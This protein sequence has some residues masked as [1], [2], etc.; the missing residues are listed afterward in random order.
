MFLKDAT[1]IKFYLMHSKY[2]T[3]SSQNHCTTSSKSTSPF[4]F[5]SNKKAITNNN[6]SLEPRIR[7]TSAYQPYHKKQ[8]KTRSAEATKR[9]RTSMRAPN[10]HS[11]SSS[12]R[13]GGIFLS[14]G[15]RCRI[16]KQQQWLLVSTESV[17]LNHRNVEIS[18]RNS[19]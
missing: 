3:I 4:R 11:C 2:W 12:C 15:T 9:L 7:W 13:N 1:K 19:W 14:T 8:M 17:S 10:V 16:L 6:D 18:H 5:T